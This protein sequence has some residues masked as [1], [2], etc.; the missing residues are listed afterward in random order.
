VTTITDRTELAR[1]GGGDVI[2]VDT[3]MRG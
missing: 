3:L 2:E 1:A